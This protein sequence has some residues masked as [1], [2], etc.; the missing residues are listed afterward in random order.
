MVPH[1][2]SSFSW[3][4]ESK[5]NNI[6][7]IL[8][9]KHQSDWEEKF[10]YY[11]LKPKGRL[12]DNSLSSRYVSDSR[13]LTWI[14]QESICLYPKWNLLGRMEKISVGWGPSKK[15][16]EVKCQLAESC[17]VLS[18]MPKEDKAISKIRAPCSQQYVFLCWKYQNLSLDFPLSNNRISLFLNHIIHSWPI[19]PKH[20]TK[21]RIPTHATSE[22]K[23]KIVQL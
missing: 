10:K 14:Y 11:N 9:V 3:W 18:M 21:W 19:K 17:F 1:L 16:K 23:T 4:L 15:Q 6:T 7:L 5:R 13:K 20:T 22:Q 12:D 8:S 2:K